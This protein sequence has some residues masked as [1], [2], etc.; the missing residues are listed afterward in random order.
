METDSVT[1]E[2]IVNNY[3]FSTF[4]SEIRETKRSQRKKNRHYGG[5]LRIL[6]IIMTYHL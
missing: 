5:K 3:I 2:N 1:M 4:Q 6:S